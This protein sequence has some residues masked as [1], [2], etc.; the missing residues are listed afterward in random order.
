MEGK[1]F[2]INKYC[3]IVLE[4]KAQL[5]LNA[6]FYFGNKRIK[7]SRLDSRLL[8]ESG[9]RMEIKYGSYN[10]AYGADIEVFQNAILEIGGELGANIG[11]TIICADHISIGQHTGCD[12]MSLSAIIMGNILYRFVDIKPPLP[13]LLKNMYG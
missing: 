13:L 2:I 8:I 6:P 11:L 12:E 7:G 9:G 10:V 4:S 1:Y 5:I 3:T